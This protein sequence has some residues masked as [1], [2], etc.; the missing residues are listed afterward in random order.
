MYDR[1][2]ETN[3]ITST[4]NTTGTLWEYPL[5]ADVDNDGQ[6]DIV[7]ASNAY[8]ITCPD[9]GSKQSGIRV[10][11]SA[12]G[13]WVRTRRVWNEHTYHITNVAENG[14]VPKNELQNWKQPGLNDF[15]LNK[16][17]GNEF[18]APDGFVSVRPVCTG[19]AYSLVATVR[20]VGEAVL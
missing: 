15:R 5:V 14:A 17:P 1:T 10:F 6:A 20:N 2:T 9:D 12:N 18:S 16:Q 8:A 4:C 7:V 3:L 13:S 11:G 19:G